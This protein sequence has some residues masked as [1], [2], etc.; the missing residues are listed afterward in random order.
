M[1]QIAFGPSNVAP[2]AAWRIAQVDKSAG[3]ARLVELLGASDP[4]CRCRAGDILAHFQPLTDT[5]HSA[6]EMALKKEPT[7]STARPYLIEAIGGEPLRELARTSPDPATIYIALS[8]LSRT[9]T[10]DDLELLWKSFENPN[11]DVRVASA[12]AI[13]KI[14][15]AKDESHPP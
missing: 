4:I 8:E 9:G 7:D 13:L 10:P 14:S 1:K 5:Q 2:F 15:D 12:I 11:L 6:L 3:L